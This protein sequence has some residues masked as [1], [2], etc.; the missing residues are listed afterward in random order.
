M[1][2]MR[3]RISATEMRMAAHRVEPFGATPDG[4]AVE[5][6]TLVNSAGMEVSFL[7][8]GGTIHTLKVPDH[9][10]SMADVTPG[11]D[12]LPEYLA[13]ASYLGTIIGRY[14][15]RIACG[16][17]TLDG[18]SYQ[19]SANEGPNQLHGG[20]GGFHRALWA[21]EPFANHA[22]VGARLINL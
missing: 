21:V 10:G 4:R 8:F 9:A 13:D 16:R 19:V 22:G 1:A 5:V 2:R 17:F 15:N 6:H 14:A 7:S 12:T 3:R 11:Y 20:V 18:V